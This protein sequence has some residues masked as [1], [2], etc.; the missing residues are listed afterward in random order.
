MSTMLENVSSILP[1][2]ENSKGDLHC[3]F[4]L[5]LVQ[6]LNLTYGVHRR[7]QQRLQ[8]YSNVVGETESLKGE[9]LQRKQPASQSAW[10][11]ALARP[12]GTKSL[13][14]VKLIYEGSLFTR[15]IF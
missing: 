10:D 15:R 1:W 8:Q 2:I 3:V 7:V 13:P 5:A 6:R 4:K 11:G 12:F 14:L 9:E